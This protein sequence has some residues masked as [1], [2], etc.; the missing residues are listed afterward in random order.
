MRYF[1]FY[2]LNSL[3][4]TLAL[5]KSDANLHSFHAISILSL[6]L[7]ISGSKE[8]PLVLVNVLIM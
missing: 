8:K 3:C 2:T 1:P 4:V 5:A 7:L 6:L